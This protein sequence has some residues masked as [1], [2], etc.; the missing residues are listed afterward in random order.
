MRGAS[1]KLAEALALRAGAGRRVELL[2]VRI[3]ANV[4]W[5]GR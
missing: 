5:P 3:V 2:K 4:A 1:V